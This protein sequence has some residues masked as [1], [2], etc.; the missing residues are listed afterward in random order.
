M[1]NY[2]PNGYP[3]DSPDCH[4]TFGMR[5][6]ADD[7]ITDRYGTCSSGGASGYAPNHERE[8]FLN[9]YPKTCLQDDC[10]AFK[11]YAKLAPSNLYGPTPVTLLRQGNDAEDREED[12]A[13]ELVFSM[14]RF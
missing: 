4:S 6:N 8:S 7:F 14:D 2:H 10:T 12:Y 1:Y 13:D 5:H 9:P 11:A 3:C